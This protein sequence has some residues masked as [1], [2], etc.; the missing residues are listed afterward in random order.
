MKLFFAIL[1]IIASY[2][3]AFTSSIQILNADSYNVVPTTADEVKAH[4]ILKNISN[5]AINIKMRFE[6]ISI[7]NGQEIAFCWG[8]ICYPPKDEPFEPN[9]VITLQP[10]QTS[11]PNEFYVTFYPNGLEGTTKGKFILWVEGNPEDSVHWDVTFV[12]QI[13]NV[14]NPISQAKFNSFAFTKTISNSILRSIDE[15][16]LRYSIFDIYGQIVS[17]NFVDGDIDI[18]LLQN[19]TYL[20]VLYSNSK[21]DYVKFIKF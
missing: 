10:E 14:A 17:N 7:T 2:E 9:D 13:G 4:C 16:P 11:S 8:P 15:N 3:Y 12:V 1:L 20:L 18:S 21:V 6:P 19:G 5:S